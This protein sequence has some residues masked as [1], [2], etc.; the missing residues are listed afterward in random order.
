MEN[1]DDYNPE[2]PIYYNY[3]IKHFLVKDSN[4]LADDTNQYL[5]IILCIYTINTSGKYPFIQYLL[6]NNG[7]N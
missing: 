6:S 7:F 5:K 4:L 1:N 3:T 2:K